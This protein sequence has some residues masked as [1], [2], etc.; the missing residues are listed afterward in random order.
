MQVGLSC[1]FVTTLYTTTRVNIARVVSKSL[2]TEIQF[3]KSKHSNKHSNV[4]QWLHCT[5]N[6]FS[7]SKLWFFSAFRNSCF[8]E[9]TRPGTLVEHKFAIAEKQRK[10]KNKLRKNKQR[11]NC[12][13]CSEV[14][15]K[16][17]ILPSKKWWQTT[18]YT[19]WAKRFFH[20][21]EAGGLGLPADFRFT[22]L[23]E[24]LPSNERKG[25]GRDAEV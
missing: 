2:N 20:W 15:N 7:G 4:F 22:S 17:D 16:T 10:R 9:E 18:H 1:H 6:F 11:K 21:F 13:T 19:D 12:W 8:V 14:L 25:I 24:T 3:F 5:A 23:N